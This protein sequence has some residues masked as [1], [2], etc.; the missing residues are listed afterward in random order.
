MTCISF[1]D[2]I[3]DWKWGVSMDSYEEVEISTEELSDLPD[4][5]QMYFNEISRYPLLTKEEEKE[6]LDNIKII[7]KVNL[8]K[9]ERIDGY[10]KVDM[11]IEQLF[12]ELID[13]GDIYEEVISS[14][15]PIYRSNENTGMKEIYDLLKKYRSKSR[16]LGRALNRDEIEE[17]TPLLPL[18]NPYMSKKEVLN[19]IKNFVI[20]KNAENKLYCSNL[21]L[22]VSVAKKHAKDIELMDAIADGNF[23]LLKAIENYDSSFETKFSTYAVP[24]I[25]QNIDRRRGNYKSGVSI[26]SYLERD[27]SSFRKQIY[28][29]EKELGRI[30]SVEEVVEYT[31]LYKDKARDLYDYH[32]QK[33][34]SLDQ[35]IE[36]EDNDKSSLIDFVEDPRSNLEDEVMKQQLKEDIQIVFKDL[37]PKQKQVLELRYGINNEYPMSGA[38]VARMLNVSREAVRITE[39]A[40]LRKIRGMS[41]NNPKVKS[42]MEYMDKK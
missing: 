4:I 3:C 9:I 41:R 23:G 20:Y 24:W 19:D 13:K 1:F 5:I 26:P 36:G 11:D 16:K 14:L 17:L 39:C 21:K 34:V 32:Y 12:V 6:Y 8:K 40:A 35:R 10:R 42:L 31:G 28:E 7:D 15:L 37:T 2:I 33:A 22:V 18:K 38:E 30:P 27:L 29:L 25:K